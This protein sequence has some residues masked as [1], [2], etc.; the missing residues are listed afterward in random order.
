M[1]CHVL[2]EMSS[3][4]ALPK[5]VGSVLANA[6]SSSS[7]S[8]GSDGSGSSGGRAR[9]RVKMK[10]QT[11]TTTTTRTTTGTT[12]TR[13]KRSECHQRTENYSTGIEPLLVWSTV[14]GLFVPQ[15]QLQLQLQSQSMAFSPFDCWFLASARFS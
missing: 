10:G 2:Y 3:A 6:N 11:T 5:M 4:S 14:A 12:T 13:M 7:G 8:G 1:S 15:P 9:Y